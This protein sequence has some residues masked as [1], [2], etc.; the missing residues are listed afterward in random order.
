M[1]GSL[2]TSVD[3]VRS[4]I[5]DRVHDLGGSDE[6]AGEI[7]LAACYAMWCTACSSTPPR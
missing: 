5:A 2:T 7:A 3:V 4:A 6:V 1:N